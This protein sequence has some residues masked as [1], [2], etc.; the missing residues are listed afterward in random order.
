[1]TDNE[2]TDVP[3]DLRAETAEGAPEVAEHDR[4]AELEAALAEAKQQAL[5]AQAEIQNV[6]RRAE[7][8][9]ADARAYAATNFARDVLS[10]NDNLERALASI[11]AELREDDKLKGLVAGLE[12]TMRELANVFQR[13][14]IT[15]ITALGETLDP[16]RHQA[17]MEMPSA[18]AAPGTIVQ[19]MQSG[20]MI[21]DR[22]LRPALVGVA[23]AAD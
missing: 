23:K 14:G 13:N 15:R 12:A 5:Y 10:V 7:K 1:M 4:T 9:A 11:P 8:D 2:N 6:R 21:R 3:E 17:M 20:W 16:N 19:E 18:D 22:L